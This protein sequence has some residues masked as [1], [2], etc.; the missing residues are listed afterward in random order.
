MK[1]VLFYI[2]WFSLTLSFIFFVMYGFFHMQSQEENDFPEWD[3]NIAFVLDVSKSMLVRDMWGD[4]RLDVAKQKILTT[5]QKHPGAEFSLS[6]FAGESQRILPFTRDIWLIVT[7]LSGISSDNLTEQGTEISLALEDSLASFGDN[8]TGILIMLTD[9][10]EE[11]VLLES[12]LKDSLWEQQL[13]IK[14]VWVGTQDWGNIL[15]GVDPFGRPIYKMFQWQRVVS[16]LNDFWLKIL[17]SDLW[18][19]YYDIGDDLDIRF[20]AWWLPVRDERTLYLLILSACF[21][22]V[23]VV[24]SILPIFKKY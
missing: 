15:E 22:I 12:E 7:F 13:D 10:A 23:F 2:S 5:M 9:G 4:S 6:I 8:K 21:W 16:I 24:I 17:A 11:S 20:W 18:G 19:K 14:I 3:T 1:K